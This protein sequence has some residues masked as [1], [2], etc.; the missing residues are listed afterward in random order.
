[1]AAALAI[2]PENVSRSDPPVPALSK[3]SRFVQII[4]DLSAKPFEDLR[5]VDLG[6]LEGMQAIELAAHGATVLGIEGREQN[7]AKAHENKEQAGVERVD[8]ALDDVR[9][10]SVERYG[11]F[12]VVLCAG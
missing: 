8:F 7:L 4:S 2:N 10:L 1:M 9:N 5:I 3:L 11:H 6:C 12:D